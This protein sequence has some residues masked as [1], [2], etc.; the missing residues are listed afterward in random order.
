MLRDAIGTR[1]HGLGP[2]NLDACSFHPV[3]ARFLACRVQSLT[4]LRQVCNWTRDFRVVGAF[5][6]IW[7]MLQAAALDLCHERFVG[8]RRA[9]GRSPAKSGLR[10]RNGACPELLNRTAL[11]CSGHGSWPFL[12]RR[13]AFLALLVSTR[14]RIVGRPCGQ[15]QGCWRVP[16]AKTGIGRALRLQRLTADKPR[17]R[18]ILSISGMRRAWPRRENASWATRLLTGDKTDSCEA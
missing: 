7:A 10:G 14:C 11:D 2:F 1:K 9:S 4:A 18:R 16:G 13:G 3:A 15:F 5:G 8:S 6:F 17:F 12:P